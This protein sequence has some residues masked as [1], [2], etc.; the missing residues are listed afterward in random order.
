MVRGINTE[1]SKECNTIAIAIECWFKILS[2][3]FEPGPDRVCWK[4]LTV[5]WFFNLITPF[6]LS[7]TPPK[8]AFVACCQGLTILLQ[9]KSQMAEEIVHETIKGQSSVNS[10][11]DGPDQSTP[12]SPPFCHHPS[13]SSCARAYVVTFTT[14]SEKNPKLLPVHVLRSLPCPPEVQVRSYVFEVRDVK[15]QG[16]KVKVSRHGRGSDSRPVR[17]RQVH[18]NLCFDNT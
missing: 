12:L 15:V 14:C 3:F 8:P 1:G 9:K 13:P 2:L 4:A 7:A 11:A 17:P 6:L 10:M 18:S 16:E 5:P